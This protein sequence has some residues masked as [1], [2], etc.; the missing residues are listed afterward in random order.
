MADQVI[1]STM[2]NPTESLVDSQYL[3]TAV[4]RLWMAG[5]GVDWRSYYKGEQR[6]RVALPTYPF[7]RQRYWVEARNGMEASGG[8]RAGAERE[9]IE[10]REEVETAQ[11]K[12]EADATGGPASLHPRPA[13]SHAYVAP[14][15]DRERVIAAIWQKALGVDKVGA[16]D[17][18]FELSGDSLT[19][20]QVISQLKE[21]FMVDIPVAS[22]YE[23]LT[24]RSVGTLIS[25]LKGEDRLINEPGAY[26][27]D[28]EDRLLQRKRF[29]GEQLL[30]R[31]GVQ[32]G[33]ADVPASTV[34]KT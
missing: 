28:R 30:R 7:Q 11:F 17:N 14:G 24:V 15:N 26:S 8:N 13:L 34:K 22:L 31:R 33:P 16:E 1:I 4:G 5:V 23:R 10:T 12:T 21:E 27:I 32:T 18:F 6:R 2:R 19:A 20:I 29:Q 25:S 9:E 3:M